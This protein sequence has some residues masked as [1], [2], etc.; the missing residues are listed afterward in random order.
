MT[1]SGAY[2][3]NDDDDSDENISGV[4]ARKRSLQVAGTLVFLFI[5]RELN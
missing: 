5:K 2:Y 3:P 4:Q 1:L